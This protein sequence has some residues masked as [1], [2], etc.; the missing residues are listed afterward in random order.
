VLQGKEN[1]QLAAKKEKEGL[2]AQD[3]VSHK[4]KLRARMAR[5]AQEQSEELAVGLAEAGAGAGGG[6]AGS[7]AKID[8]TEPSSF[9]R[10]R[11]S[12]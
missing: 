9:K 1:Q 2:V 5:K 11:S 12:E 10:K 3:K 7:A 6:G 4:D 8:K